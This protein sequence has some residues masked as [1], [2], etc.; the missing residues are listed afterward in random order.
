MSLYYI[1]P[2]GLTLFIYA[3]PGAKKTEIDGCHDGRLKVKLAG[4]PVDGKANKEL[5][6]FLAAHVG[7]SKSRVLLIRG[8]KSRKK[9]VLLKMESGCIEKVRIKGWL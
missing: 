3:Q 7:L 9:E 6:K 1:C 4:P 8:T 5:I 2:D